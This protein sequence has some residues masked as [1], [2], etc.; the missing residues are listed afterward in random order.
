LF[1]DAW[2]LADGRAIFDA[3]F[4]DTG[5]DGWLFTAKA[6]GGVFA[7]SPALRDT[8]SA[9]WSAKEPRAQF[10]EATPDGVVVFRRADGA[11][12]VTSIDHANDATAAMLG[13]DVV[14]AEGKP[15][16]SVVSVDVPLLARG[17]E[18]LIASARVKGATVHEAV[19]LASRADVQNGK[20]EPLLEVGAAVPQD[21]K[22]RMIQSIR[23]YE[24][25]DE[26][27]WG[28]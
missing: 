4:A 15:Q 9:P 10:L 26:L 11:A 16:G 18:W 6:G 17:G 13:A 14:G 19:L 22:K 21:A 3:N 25:R 23:F 8:K 20:V 27:L 2:L 28:K 7:L 1:G 24:G 12:I 5:A